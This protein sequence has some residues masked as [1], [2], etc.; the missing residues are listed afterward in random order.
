MMCDVRRRRRRTSAGNVVC[1]S[2]ACGWRGG[3]SDRWTARSRDWHLLGSIVLL[4]LLL[5]AV[6]AARQ[7]PV[8]PLIE[9]R[10]AVIPSG[11]VR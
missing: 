2:S 6:V 11:E 10:R 4:G 8:A 5:A 9:V 3:A 7:P 1:H